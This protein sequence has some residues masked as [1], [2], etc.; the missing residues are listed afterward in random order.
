[1]FVIG[2]LSSWE[3]FAAK[4]LRTDSSWRSW[5]TSLRMRSRPSVSPS[6]PCSVSA[7]MRTV[8]GGPPLSAIS[9]APPASPASVSATKRWISG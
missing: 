4:S 1:M 6:L 8:R 2:V 5:V 9:D 7:T 3:T